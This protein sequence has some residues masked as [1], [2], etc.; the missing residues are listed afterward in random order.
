MF[1]F[2]LTVC[3]IK[4]PGRPGSGLDFLVLHQDKV[5]CGELALRLQPPP[6]SLPRLG[7]A[8][9]HE[10]PLGLLVGTPGRMCQV[11]RSWA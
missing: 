8:A 4:H 6:P 11:H 1:C 2:Y 7:L 9:C 3:L 5:V 10:D